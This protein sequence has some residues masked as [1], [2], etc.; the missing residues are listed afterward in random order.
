MQRKQFPNWMS[1][2]IPI[3]KTNC[4]DDERE[5]DSQVHSSLLSRLQGINSSDQ[6][7]SIPSPIEFKR[8][9]RTVQRE[10]QLISLLFAR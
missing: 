7:Q 9:F 8:S 3:K 1:T 6:V 5:E 4:S 2:P 10:R